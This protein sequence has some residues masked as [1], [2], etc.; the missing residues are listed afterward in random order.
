MASTV[1]AITETKTTH[2]LQRF[3]L[4][5]QEWQNACITGGWGVMIMAN[6][7][8]FEAPSYAGFYGPAEFW[9]VAFMVVSVV[10]FTALYVNGTIPKPT[11]MLRTLAAGMQVFLYLLL[12]MGFMFSGTG[13]PGITT[14]GFLAFFGGLGGIWALLDAVKPEYANS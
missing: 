9:A 11:A 4:R 14:Y 10:S 5:V 6:P 1:K 3:R 13:T 7:E 12:F 8:Q 2:L